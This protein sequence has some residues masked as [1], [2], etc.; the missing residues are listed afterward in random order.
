M[1]IGII[2]FCCPWLLVGTLLVG[3]SRADAQSGLTLESKIQ[4]GDIRGRLDHMAFDLRRQRLFVAELENDSVGVI[5]FGTREIAHVITDVRRPQGLAYVP[6]ADTL[7]VANGGDGL[8]RMFE[9]AQYRALEPLHVGDDA[10]NLRFDPESNLVYVAYGEGALGII[11]V[12]SR[13]KIRDLRLTAH[14]ESFQLEKQSNRIYVNVPKEL[15]IIVLDRASGLRLANWQIGNASN[16]PLALNVAA[17][18]VLVVFRNPTSL[19]AFDASS[20]TPVA[21]VEACGDADDML[22]DASRR[23]IYV[24][25]G[26]GFLD[27]FDAN[28]YKLVERIPTVK[29]ART[30]LL[31]P[32]IDRLFVAARATAETPA[33]IWVFRPGP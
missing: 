28:P 23:R 32:E 22:V 10:D 13:R 17:G 18:H 19:V 9:G 16:F 2:R 24:S 12:A 8:L 29:G 26:D 11:D 1:Q 33:A 21:K 31:V 5:D 27:V 7:F 4:L 6:S 3:A 30:S 15:A 25:C 20:G 14:P